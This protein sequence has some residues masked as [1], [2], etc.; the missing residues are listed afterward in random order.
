MMQPEHRG[1]PHAFHTCTHSLR[2]RDKKAWLGQQVSPTTAG[3]GFNLF[4]THPT[5]KTRLS[6]FHDDYVAWRDVTCWTRGDR[7][8]P[9]L[10]RAIL[11]RIEDL[12]SQPKQ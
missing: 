6:M 2:P 9:L 12:L 4:D 5:A 7:C 1:H 11:S 3:S 8:L 10:L